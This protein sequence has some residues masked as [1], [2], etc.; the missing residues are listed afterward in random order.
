VLA[1]PAG[2]G[3]TRHDQ[4]LRPAQAPASDGRTPHEPLTAA[5]QAAG[6]IAGDK[7][8]GSPGL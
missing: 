5:M 6:L 4:G 2:T 3:R 8:P 1:P 7:F